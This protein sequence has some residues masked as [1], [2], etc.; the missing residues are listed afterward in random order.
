MVMVNKAGPADLKTAPKLLADAV[1]LLARID[2]TCKNRDHALTAK[3]FVFSNHVNEAFNALLENGQIGRM[4]AGL[5][6]TIIHQ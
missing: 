2:E 5:V 4:E 1:L 3:K 6:L